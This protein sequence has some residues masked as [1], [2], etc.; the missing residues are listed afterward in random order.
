LIF[1]LLISLC[2]QSFALSGTA[3]KE[4]VVYVNLSKGG[5]VDAIHVVNSFELDQDGR[6][7]DYGDYTAFREMTS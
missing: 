6:I 1:A 7:I 4:E 3:P 2:V 5:S